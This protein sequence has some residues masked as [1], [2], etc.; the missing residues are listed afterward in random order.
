MTLHACCCSTDTEKGDGI[1]DLAVIGAGSAGF[2]AG[3]SAAIAAAELGAQVALIGHGTIAGTCTNVGCV[4]SKTMIRAIETLHQAEA[5]SR[6]AGIRAEGRITDWRQVVRQR[7]SWCPSSGK[8]STSISCPATTPSLTKKAGR[9][10]PLTERPLTENRSKPAESSS[11]PA[12]PRR[13]HRSRGSSPCPISPARLLW[14]SCSS[15]SH[16]S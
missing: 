1:Y 14:S 9:T 7:T 6:F 5:A 12:Q 16:Y 11:R 10:L 2:S 13:C 3:F 15:R 4:P 8:R